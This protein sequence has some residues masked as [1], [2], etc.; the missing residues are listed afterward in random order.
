MRWRFNEETMGR[1]TELQRRLAT[2]ASRFLARGGHLVYS[3]CSVLQE[4]NEEQV[5]AICKSEKMELV[6]EPFRSLP[7][8]GGMDGFFAAVMRRL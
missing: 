3:T 7:K 4:E 5:V 2:T 1:L 8:Q 6:G